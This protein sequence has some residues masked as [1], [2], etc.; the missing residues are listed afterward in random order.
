MLAV[1]AASCGGMEGMEAE[2]TS[3]LSVRDTAPYTVRDG[4]LLFELD[5]RQLGIL[6]IEVRGGR[7]SG[8][9]VFQGTSSVDEYKCTH[10]PP[11]Q[12]DKCTCGGYTGAGSGVLNA[13]DCGFLKIDCA[14]GAFS[15]DS[16]SN[17]DGDPLPPP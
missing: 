17:W 7:A 6:R 1:A 9:D 10:D 16:C 5:R 12:G 2:S 11:Q 13:I 14:D 4:D 15:G 3:P 8:I